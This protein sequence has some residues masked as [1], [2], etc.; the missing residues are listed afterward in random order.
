MIVKR[1]NGLSAANSPITVSDTTATDTLAKPRR[2]L[3]ATIKLSGSGTTTATLTL[4]SSLGSGY[5]AELGSVAISADTVG[6]FI[7]THDHLIVLP[8]DALDFLVPAAGAGVTAS[9]ALYTEV[10]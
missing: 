8:E 7:P 4:N 1:T 3:Y 5:D 2:V 6:V 9:V 10:V